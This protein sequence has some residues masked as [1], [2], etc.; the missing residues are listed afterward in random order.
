M[1]IRCWL[2]AMED[3]IKALE[4]NDTWSLVTIPKSV[5]MV[6]LK[7]IFKTKLH[8]DGIVDMLKARLLAQGI[9]MVVLYDFGLAIDIFFLSCQRHVIC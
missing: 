5:N 9:F 7:W 2:E 8:E 6:G 3:E 1:K 4:N